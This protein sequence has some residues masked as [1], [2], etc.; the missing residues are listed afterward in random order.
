LKE[1]REAIQKNRGKR[2]F[3]RDH[4]ILFRVA[5]GFTALLRLFEKKAHNFSE[6]LSGADQQFNDFPI[7]IPIKL[8]ALCRRRRED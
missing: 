8:D 5:N 7:I 2:L 4:L 1:N 3:D 6:S